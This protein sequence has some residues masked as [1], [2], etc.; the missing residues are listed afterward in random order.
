MLFKKH[1]YDRRNNHTHSKH[2]FQELNPELLSPVHGGGGAGHS[3]LNVTRAV[4]PGGAAEFSKTGGYRLDGVASLVRRPAPGEIRPAYVLPT[5]GADGSNTEEGRRLG[6]EPRRLPSREVSVCVCS[7][8]WMP[9]ARKIER[10]SVMPTK[11]T[12]PLD[13]D[14]VSAG[15]LG[16]LRLASNSSSDT[17]S[18]SSV[19]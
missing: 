8:A 14:L 18:A 5:S 12:G 9:W 15:A 1:Q 3:Q 16:L 13:I 7:L 4:L 11:A 6:A 10:S 19:S 17:I 2:Y